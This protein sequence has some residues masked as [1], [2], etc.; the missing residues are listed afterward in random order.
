MA[1]PT[2][3]SLT[4]NLFEQANALLEDPITYTPDG[5]VAQSIRAWVNHEDKTEAFQ[6]SQITDQDIFVEVLKSDVATV[7]YDDV[8]YLPELAQSFSPRDWKNSA[9]GRTWIIMCKRV[10]A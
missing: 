6:G 10:R 9:S 7:A 4:D 2:L 5:G 8:I 3:D 1:I